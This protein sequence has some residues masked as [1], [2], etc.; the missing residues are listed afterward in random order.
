MEISC[1][2][3]EI[4]DLHQELIGRILSALSGKRKANPVINV[5][6]PKTFDEGL[7]SKG[8]SEIINSVRYYRIREYNLN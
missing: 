5:V 4:Y 3:S 6:M 7:G 8:F 2:T 1:V